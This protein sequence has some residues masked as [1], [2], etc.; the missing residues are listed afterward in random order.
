MWNIVRFFYEIIVMWSKKWIPNQYTNNYPKMVILWQYYEIFENSD[1]WKK[2]SWSTVNHNY[3]HDV[4]R[5]TTK[6]TIVPV[7]GTPQLHTPVWWR[8]ISWKRAFRLHYEP[9][10]EKIFDRIF[11]KDISQV[12]RFL[13]PY[14]GMTVSGMIPSDLPLWL[15]LPLWHQNALRDAFC[16]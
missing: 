1:T 9:G 16:V 10:P 3:S 13:V 15:R 4:Y 12:T 5:R 7:W 6:D 8:T 11:T 14:I 2:F